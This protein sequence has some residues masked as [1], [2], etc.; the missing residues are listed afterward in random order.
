MT[1]FLPIYISANFR[2]FYVRYLNLHLYGIFCKRATAVFWKIDPYNGRLS[3]STTH[4]LPALLCSLDLSLFVIFDKL[5]IFA[6]TYV[7]NRCC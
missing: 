7:I 6:I 3:E 4:S 5:C 1:A 2:V